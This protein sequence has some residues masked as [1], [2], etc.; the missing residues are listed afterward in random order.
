MSRSE[1]VPNPSLLPSLSFTSSL[2]VAIPVTSTALRW[3]VSFTCK[4]PVKDPIPAIVMSPVPLILR[5]LRSKLP[6]SLGVSSLR[7]SLDPPPLLAPPPGEA[8]THW[9]LSIS[10]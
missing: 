7:R 8:S 6:P 3:E 2:K 1:S 10:W 5:L 4:V 9:E